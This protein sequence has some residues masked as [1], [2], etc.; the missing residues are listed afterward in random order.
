MGGGA[1]AD[2]ATGGVTGTMVG[3]VATEGVTAE[4]VTVR[5]MPPISQIYLP[6]GRG[7]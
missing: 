5:T 1:G 7:T 4:D 2:G 6:R 3:N